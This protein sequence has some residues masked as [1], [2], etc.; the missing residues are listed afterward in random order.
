MSRVDIDPPTLA[1]YGVS[2][3]VG[4]CVCVLWWKGGGGHL[5]SACGGLVLV[6]A[7]LLS[8]RIPATVRVALVS[9][10]GLSTGCCSGRRPRVVLLILLGRR[11]S[12]TGGSCGL[13][14]R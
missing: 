6:L 10:P 8:A 13:L 14:S 4:A 1:D 5:A 3:L 11:R 9:A 7:T 2:S 12:V